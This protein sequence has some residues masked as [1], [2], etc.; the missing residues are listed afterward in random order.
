[1]HFFHALIFH[2]PSNEVCKQ[3]EYISSD[4]LYIHKRIGHTINVSIVDHRKKVI[5]SLQMRRKNTCKG[6]RTTSTID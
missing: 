6:Q 4:L 3:Q 2:L 5:K 1:M